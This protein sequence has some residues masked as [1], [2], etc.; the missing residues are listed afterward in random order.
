[1]NEVFH[2]WAVAACAIRDSAIK[3]RAYSVGTFYEE[4]A[5]QYAIDETAK[6]YPPSD[7]WQLFTATHKLYG[8]PVLDEEVL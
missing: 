8:L 2:G 7:G 3:L 1:M 5:R 4:D 6:D